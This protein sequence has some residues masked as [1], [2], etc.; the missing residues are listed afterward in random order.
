MAGILGAPAS[1]APEFNAYRLAFAILYDK[2]FEEVRTKRNLSYAPAAS[3]SGGF[4]PFAE[5][6]VTTTKPKEAVNVMVDE[7]KRLRNGGFTE[8]DLKDAKSK[9][10]TSYFM[11][12]IV[13]SGDSYS[14]C[15]SLYSGMQSS[16]LKSIHIT[17]RNTTQHAC[18][19]SV[20]IICLCLQRPQREDH[21]IIVRIGGCSCRIP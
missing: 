9:L 13:K 12:N 14:F 17:R 2:L 6:Y 10:M 11:M 1:T 7:I 8:I 19:Q 16:E 21:R 4:L 5:I 18:V 20:Y 3:L 15:G